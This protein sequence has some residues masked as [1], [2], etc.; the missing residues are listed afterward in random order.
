MQNPIPLKPENKL[1]NLSIDTNSAAP[2]K[3][4]QYLKDITDMDGDDMD[5]DIDVTGIKTPLNFFKQPNFS[6]NHFNENNSSSITPCSTPLNSTTTT[7][8]FYKSNQNQNSNMSLASTVSDYPNYNGKQ[9]KTKQQ[10]IINSSK[11]FN[12]EFTKL[13]LEIYSDFASDPLVTPF[14]YSNPPSG[15]L[16]R[17]AKISVEE[18][19]KKNIEIGVDTNNWLLTLIRFKLQ[20]EIKNEFANSRANSVT[21]VSSS[22]PTNLQTNFN[23]LISNYANNINNTN[24]T[25]NNNINNTPIA[26]GILQPAAFDYFSRPISTQD[27]ISNNCG[28]TLSR[29]PLTPVSGLPPN[30]AQLTRP[31]SNSSQTFAHLPSLSRT[32]SHNL[33]L[34]NQQR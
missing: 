18:S 22:I 27:I 16:N 32:A 9:D 28:N 30:L 5:V 6:I 1:L 12:I 4:K 2:N 7:T 11:Y 23:D 34:Q 26:S 14:D 17:V 13:L 20:Q 24:S 10:F 25:C 21:S 29:G 19:K 8:N 15:V 33:L 31:R 3:N